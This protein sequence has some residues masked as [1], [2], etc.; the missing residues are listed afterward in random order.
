MEAPAGADVVDTSLGDRVNAAIAGGAIGCAKLIA[1]GERRRCHR[2]RSLLLK[3]SQQY[4]MCSLPHSSTAWVS[5]AVS[6]PAFS[7][8]IPSHWSC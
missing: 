6:S 3:S 2:L 7:S 4:A 1:P 8:T 5:T